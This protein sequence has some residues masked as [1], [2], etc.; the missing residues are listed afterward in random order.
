MARRS[1]PVLYVDELTLR[2]WTAADVPALA[3]AYADPAIQRWHARSMTRSEASR[4]VSAANRSWA[5]ET[6]ANWA[7]TASDGLVGRMS[8]RTVDLED[9]LAGIGYWVVPA[10]RGRCIAPRALVA[11]SDWAIDELGL[12]RLE[13]EHSTRNEPSCRVAEKAGYPLESTK[14]SQALHDDGW[15][16]MHLHVRIDECQCR[17]RPW[18]P[19]SAQCH[20]RLVQADP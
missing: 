13:L 2:P 18:P 11:V 8:L 5:R 16:D 9:G 12:H 17:R 20:S 6:A 1:Q 4:W 19:P 15:H 7:V 3:A 10:A 14:W